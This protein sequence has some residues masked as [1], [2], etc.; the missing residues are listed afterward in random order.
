MPSLLTKVKTLI[1]EI[2]N[3][4]IEKYEEFGPFVDE[5]AKNVWSMLTQTGLELKYDSV[6]NALYL[7]HFSSWF[8]N[9]YLF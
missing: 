1:L 9:L 2:L 4:Y 6:R 8:Q 3:V 7:T 5:F